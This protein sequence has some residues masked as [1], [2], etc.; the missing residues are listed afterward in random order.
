MLWWLSR[1]SGTAVSQL[2][3]L[4]KKGSLLRAFYDQP[5]VVHAIDILPP[6]LTPQ[7]HQ[8]AQLLNSW[9]TADA[10]FGEAGALW[11]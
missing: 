1:G 7:C 10:G 8:R 11:W 9:G 5:V 3:L 6:S 4:A 2:Q